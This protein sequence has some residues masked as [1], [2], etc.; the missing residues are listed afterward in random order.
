MIGLNTNHHTI[1]HTLGAHVIAAC[2]IDKSHVVG[3]FI[4]HSLLSVSIEDRYITRSEE[5]L[6]QHFHFL[7]NLLL[8]FSKQ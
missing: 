1:R 5:V 2:V 3:C 6:P 8:A 7:V 4:I